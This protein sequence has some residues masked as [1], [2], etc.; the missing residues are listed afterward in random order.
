LLSPAA[1]LTLFLL[2]CAAV[3]PRSAQAGITYSWNDDEAMFVTGSFVVSSSTQAA[4]EIQSSNVISFTFTINGETFTSHI[5]NPTAD[6]T[7]HYPLSISTV[8]ASPTV[9]QEITATLTS[10]SDTLEID[11]NLRW[12]RTFEESAALSDAAG[13]TIVSDGGH[14]TIS[15]VSS[16]PSVPEPST[17]ILAV[18]GAVAFIAYGWSRRRR[19]QR[20][21]AA[22]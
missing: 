4:G 16:P 3:V 13:N 15:E 20:R 19:D 1:V 22:A 10:N 9:M 17:A 2:T 6:D 18:C 5:T 7:T 12:N 8:D 21:L 11:F 14:W